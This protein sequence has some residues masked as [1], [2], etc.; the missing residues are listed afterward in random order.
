VN[1]VDLIKR[2]FT[3]A[4]NMIVQS[5]RGLAFGRDVLPR[6]FLPIDEPEGLT[7]LQTYVEAHETGPGIW[8]WEHYL[9]VYERH[10][11]KFKGREVHVV[12][13]GVYSGG[14]LGMW[15]DYFGPKAHIYGVDIGPECESFKGPGVDI[16]IGD[17]ADPDFWRSF[18][19][20]VPTVDVV[21]DDGG[22][23]TF[24]QIATLEALLPHIRP[25]GIYVCEDIGGEYNPFLDYVFGLSRG[26][27]EYP[28]GTKPNKGMSPS[29]IQLAL[30]SFHF[31]PFVTV[32]EKRADRLDRLISSKHGTEWQPRDFRAAARRSVQFPST[33]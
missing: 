33:A 3:R 8:K 25:G 5:R 17:Q 1:S 2:R 24:Q 21:I 19:K 9:P 29:D 13:I 12:E 27:H 32:V 16:F 6:G 20:D 22:H 7:E 26:L 11:E 30:D 23:Q 18:V 4:R 10:F 14:S 31:Y 15:K 28:Y